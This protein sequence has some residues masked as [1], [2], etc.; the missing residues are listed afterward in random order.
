MA[1]NKLAGYS[2]VL[3]SILLFVSGLPG[4]DGTHQGN[5]LTVVGF[6][7]IIFGAITLLAPYLPF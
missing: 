5:I 3:A 7:G 6:T 1:T 4:M 2:L